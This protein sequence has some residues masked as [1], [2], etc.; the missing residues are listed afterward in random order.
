MAP[1]GRR[2]KGS[3]DVL[4]EAI[5]AGTPVATA[6]EAA[7]MSIRSAYRRLSE[8][9]TAE[10]VREAQQA[11]MTRA[12][13]RLTALHGRALDTLEDLLDG[14]Q[15]GAVRARAVA[16]V[17]EARPRLVETVELEE[18]LGVLEQAVQAREGRALAVA[19]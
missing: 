13:R 2:R 19:Q 3:E 8:P 12:V 18:R 4:A 10:R 14:E 11:S 6:A 7:G 1:A 15:P 9:G 16:L 17:L 5:A